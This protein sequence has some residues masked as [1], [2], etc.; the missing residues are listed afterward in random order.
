MLTICCW[1]AESLMAYNYVDLNHVGLAGCKG[2]FTLYTLQQHCVQTLI[3]CCWLVGS[4]TLS[5][6]QC[7]SRA[8]RLQGNPQS[9]L[10]S[11][12]LRR[13]LLWACSRCCSRSPTMTTSRWCSWLPSPCCC[14]SSR[15]ASALHLNKKDKKG[16]E[17]SRNQKDRERNRKEQEKIKKHGAHHRQGVVDRG[18]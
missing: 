14:K 8:A 12:Q 15:S 17:K 1:L 3:V 7:S 18:V 4:A 10:R 2:I 6:W 13:A 5:T 9:R 16:K 11:R